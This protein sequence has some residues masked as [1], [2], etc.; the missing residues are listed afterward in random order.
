MRRSQPPTSVL[1][2]ASFVS[3][4]AA[5]V[6]PDSV[7]TALRD[8]KTKSATE[9]TQ[10]MD[11]IM[12]SQPCL[13]AL[14]LGA[15]KRKVQNE[16]DTTDDIMLRALLRGCTYGRCLLLRQMWQAKKEDTRFQVPFNQPIL[17]Y[18]LREP[19][20]YPTEHVPVEDVPHRMR[21]C[22]LGEPLPVVSGNLQMVRALYDQLLWVYENG[23][24]WVE[25][26]WVLYNKAHARFGS[27]LARLVQFLLT[28]NVRFLSRPLGGDFRIAFQQLYWLCR[29]LPPEILTNLGAHQI[30][31]EWLKPASYNLTPL[32][33]CVT[34]YIKDTIMAHPAVPDPP[35]CNHTA[36]GELQ[37]EVI[38][39]S[40]L[41]CLEV[42]VIRMDTCV[43]T[44]SD[45]TKLSGPL[46]GAAVA[47]CPR[48]RAFVL[49]FMRRPHHGH[50]CLFMVDIPGRRQTLFDPSG[51]ALDFYPN[52]HDF[53]RTNQL[54]GAPSWTCEVVR[55]ESSGPWKTL[56]GYFEPDDKA[57]RGSCASVCLL[58]LVFCLRFNCWDMQRMC[59][60]MRLVI[61]R[62]QRSPSASPNLRDR[63]VSMLYTW[64]RS[65]DPLPT[66]EVAGAPI[67]LTDGWRKRGQ[68]LLDVFHVR[69][70]PTDVRT[71]R[72]CGVVLATGEPCSATPAEGWALCKAHL[73]EHLQV[74]DRNAAQVLE[75]PW[76]EPISRV[77][78]RMPQMFHVESED[79]PSDDC[80][81]I[82]T[83]ICH[84]RPRDPRAVP[85][86]P[87]IGVLENGAEQF[88]ILR[89]VAFL[90]GQPGDFLIFSQ[91]LKAIPWDSIRAQNPRMLVEIFVPATQD[92]TEVR[93]RVLRSVPMNDWE[94]LVVL[95]QTIDRAT[96]QFV[97]HIDKV[98]KVRSVKVGRELFRPRVLAMSV[99]ATRNSRVVPRILSSNA[100]HNC[101]AFFV[102]CLVANDLPSDL[103]RLLPRSG[104]SGAIHL[105]MRK[106]TADI[107]NTVKSLLHRNYGGHILWDDK[108]I[109]GIHVEFPPADHWVQAQNRRGFV[110]GPKSLLWKYFRQQGAPQ[111]LPISP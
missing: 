3:Q 75:Q 92:I 26:P 95:A 19:L 72:I 98:T 36:R 31:L 97:E 15:G 78:N 51:A 7:L 28:G 46:V 53:F 20:V 62:F 109:P 57:K 24:E 77:H 65:L 49:F 105:V 42:P 99:D 96:K 87:N 50:D 14:G 85:P 23:T 48:Q 55:N 21:V 34:M 70:G 86:L 11:F 63:F 2:P 41:Q 18:R 107:I 25:K 29:A 60:A 110:S 69:L 27:E 90:R 84:V 17:D 71:K 52:M 47:Q 94:A 79:T 8:P 80:P 93:N 82:G 106:V 58:M 88:T 44:L 66:V 38:M 111:K 9:D 33:E 1:R 39:W 73:L 43:H 22:G 64:H 4:D 32:A 103:V 102:L 100:A 40:F 16:D 54:W 5:D 76:R 91:H 37:I 56:Q 108:L 67:P 6:L 81:S 89:L 35:R 45:W 61:H 68:L 74:N 83:V 30:L 104:E 12:S 59:D 10:L 101:L 13:E